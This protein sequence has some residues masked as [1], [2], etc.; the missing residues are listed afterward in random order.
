MLLLYQT[1]DKT[2]SDKAVH[3]FLGFILSERNYRSSYIS[4]P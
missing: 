2:L 4:E 3:L 1:N